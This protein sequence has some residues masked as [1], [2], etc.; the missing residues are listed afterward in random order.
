MT[1]ITLILAFGKYSPLFSILYKILPGF[2]TFRGN[3]KFLSVT[4]IWLALGAGKGLDLFTQEL[5]SL[6]FNKIIRKYLYIILAIT[7]LTMAIWFIIFGVFSKN[8][9]DFWTKFVEKSLSSK[10][11]YSQNSF[12]A[13]QFLSSFQNARL[14]GWKAL[15][16][17]SLTVLL[18]IWTTHTKL[19]KKKYIF[20][21]LLILIIFFDLYGF[22]KRYAKCFDSADLLPTK[23]VVEYIQKQDINKICRVMPLST[24]G[25]NDFM[26]YGIDSISGNHPN[27]LERFSN[28]FNRASHIP[29]DKPQTVTSFQGYNEWFTMANV[30]YVFLRKNDR[31]VRIGV[32]EI[33]KGG[34][35]LAYEDES[36]FLLESKLT[37]P[38][39][40]LSYNI[41]SAKDE[42][43]AFLML[44]DKNFDPYK[45]AIVEGLPLEKEIRISNE[46]DKQFK[47]LRRLEIS[48]YYLDN[49]QEGKYIQDDGSIDLYVEIPTRAL[50]ILNEIYYPGWSALV[51]NQQVKIYPVNYIQKGIILEQ[52]KHNVTFKF[53]SSFLSIGCIFSTLGTLI[54]LACLAMK[55]YARKSL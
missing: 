2:D 9:P 21:S 42:K 51:D 22:A 23:G 25:L 27:N 15:I 29:V 8:V 47:E 40:W 31:S 14:G 1:S 37:F 44:D 53:N 54:S 36:C 19:N 28:Y 3:A 45:Y 48:R 12:T 30:G 34:F 11:R 41:R 17:L 10:D 24:K 5:K 32:D 43:E 16:F 38:R 33:L 39:V 7:L 26:I 50:L 46:Q 6:E 18:M 35:S 49:Q 4:I 52:G 20:C 13:E 55:I